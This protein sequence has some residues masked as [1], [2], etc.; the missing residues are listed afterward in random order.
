MAKSRIPEYK[1]SALNKRTGEKGDVGAGWR[2]EDGSISIKLNMHV[3]LR[4]SRDHVLT[5][6][7]NTFRQPAR[8]SIPEE[9]GDGG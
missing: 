6:F 1:L 3:V 9:S 5:L 2:N 4:Q 7:P 8:S